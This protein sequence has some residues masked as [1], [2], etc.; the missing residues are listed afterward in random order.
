LLPGTSIHF[1]E[2]GSEP[3]AQSVLYS[4]PLVIEN[5]K[6][7]RA[8]V[9]GS[10]YLPGPVTTHTYLV[11][12]NP[13][14]PVIALCTAPENLWDEQTGIYVRGPDAEP[15]LPYYDANFWQDWEKPVHI[16]YIDTDGTGLYSADGGVRI[17]GGWSRANPQ[18]SLA[19]FAR[20]EYGPDAFDFPFFPDKPIRSFQSLVLRNSGNDWGFSMFRDPLV[21][22]LVKPTSLVVQAYRPVI[23]YLNGEY[24]GI[25]NLREKLN[26][27][28]IASNYGFDPDRLD[29]LEYYEAVIQG[30]SDHY[31]QMLNYIT[32]HDMHIPEYYE[33]AKTCMDMDNYIDYQVSEIYF[34][35]TDWPGTNIKFFRSEAGDAKWRWLLFDT[36]A[37]F[38]L[39][40]HFAYLH[41]TLEFATDPDGPPFPNPPWSTLLIRHL[42]DNTEFRN[43][44]INRFADYMNTLFDPD[45]IIAC[46]DSMKTGIENEMENHIEKWG[47]SLSAWEDEVEVMR[48]FARHRNEAVRTHIIGQFNL[49]AVHLLSLNVYPEKTG[50]IT[51]NTVSPSGYPWEGIY[52]QNVPVLLHADPGDGFRFLRWDGDVTGDSTCLSVD[53]TEDLSVTAVFEP[54]DIRIVINEIN[55]HA[56]H[57]ADSEDWIELVNN[58]GF[59]VDISG[60]TLQDSDEAH[61]YTFPHRTV[62]EAGAYLVICRNLSAF[63]LVFP[64]VTVVPGDLGFGL[65]GDGE[66][67]RLYDGGHHIADSLT[68]SD[69]YP[70]PA[71]PDGNGPALALKNPD[72]DNAVPENWAASNGHG[73]PGEINDVVTEA[74]EYSDVP[75]PAGS[76]LFQNY[77][78]PFNAS[79]KIRFYLCEYGSVSLKVYNIQGEEIETLFSGTKTAGDHVF[80]WHAD[81]LPGGL[82]LI[83]LKAGRFIQMRKMLYCK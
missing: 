17:F 76:C 26:E 29:I 21:Q 9:C 67:I 71:L 74:S 16:E 57:D 59:P 8:R 25:H 15:E 33:T 50:S 35:N 32:S 36:D 20:R 52:F 53:V 42:L 41:N 55:Y 6:V 60:W 23:V 54:A 19:L 56:S 82:Y 22:N 64:D 58:S 45:E 3:T 28:F 44:F 46:I 5:T 40:D 68:Y 51:I 34:D 81:R 48:E 78:N 37:C 31:L 13:S 77:P 49:E 30:E 79:T 10:G 63:R 12:G 61:E 75:A 27:H 24:W 14:L 2:D 4:V 69:R 38:G 62:L 1:T 11:T 43:G 65:N 66:H 73:T 39:Y 70:W 7:I 80:R 83:R 72:L 18:K 47:G